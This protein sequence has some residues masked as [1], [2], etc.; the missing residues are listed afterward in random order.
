LVPGTTG[1]VAGGG[2]TP[3]YCKPCSPDCV[4]PQVQAYACT[5]T[6]DRVCTAAM[7]LFTKT[8]SR[9]IT[10]NTI[11]I[12]VGVTTTGCATACYT[13]AFC[14]SFQIQTGICYLKSV[15]SP[16]TLTAGSDVYV[17]K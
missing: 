13:T 16:L 12:L 11:K 9:S 8:A 3:G 10:G 14:V 15:K 6:M 5:R 4:S 7:T 17:K 1:T 2:G